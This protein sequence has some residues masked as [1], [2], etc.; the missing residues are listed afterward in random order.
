MAL[1][2]GASVFYVTNPLM[3]HRRQHTALDRPATIRSLIK[4]PSLPTLCIVNGEYVLPA[5]WDLEVGRGDVVTFVNL[6]QGGGDSN[7]LVVL[8]AV[9]V[10]AVG[11][12]TGNPY[13]VA[14]GVGTLVSGLVGVPSFTPLATPEAS[15]SSTYSVNLQGNSARLGQTIPVPYGRHIMVPDF[16]AQPYSEYD[17]N[18]DQYYHALL[19]LGMQEMHVVEQIAI[20]D[21]TLDHFQGVQQQLIGP[22]YPGETLSIVNPAVVNAVEVAQQDVKLGEYVGPF[23]VCGPGLSTTKIGIDVAFPK[24]LYLANNNGDLQEKSIQW[25]VE[26]RSVSNAG[27]VAGIWTTLG[28]ETF[29]AAKNEP[30]RRTYNYTV[31]SGRYEVRLQRLDTRD[32]NIR[33]GHDIQWIGMRAY[34]D[35]AAPLEPN[36]VYLAL[37]IKANN[38]LSG[39]SQRRVQVIQRRMLKTWD[40]IGGWSDYVETSNPAWICADIL[41]NTIYGAKLTDDRIDLETLK[42]LADLWDSRNDQ[43]NGIFD[44]R[45]TVWGALQTVSQVGRAVPIMRSTVFT[46]VRDSLQEIPTALFSMHNIVRGSFSVTYSMRTEND[47]DGLELEY[48]DEESWASAQIVVPMPG[49]ADPI[50]VARMSMLGITKHDQAER[51]CTHRVYDSY[52]RRTRIQFDTEMEGFLPAFGDLIAVSHD[53]TGW[54]LSGEIE[55]WAS[56]TAVCT[57]D[58]V[59]GPGK[60][61]AMLVDSQGDAFGPYEVAQGA[62]DRMMTFIDLPEC[63]IYTGAEQQRTRFSVGPSEDYA[64][65]C[66]VLRL[67]PKDDDMV[68]ITAVVEDVR[69]HHDA[70][71]VG[72]GGG[73]SPSEGRAAKYAPDGLP[74]YNGATDDQQNSY[75]Y[76][77]DADRTVGA[78]DDPGYVYNP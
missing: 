26:A 27:G 75:G 71:F 22:P 8:L 1:Y 66:R 19:C 51:E 64:R 53:V 43:F 12:F 78:S 31:A 10:T 25:M 77:S 58:I 72:T 24:G 4:R 42:E 38:Q 70:S 17:E 33:A 59:W 73:Y 74:N 47:P 32:D 20:D 21:T 65:L 9:V 44:R 63:E 34:L 62:G 56:P 5:D 18:G 2:R 39:L 29:S 76:Y 3:T 13:I 45:T 52:Y 36:A 40:P 14:A 61:Y 37:R 67:Q 49:V 46:F 54:G 15:L 28:V 6:P 41:K 7:P 68:Q 30:I 16:A 35:M 57:E 48:F 11:I 60:Y 50:N 23:T 55:A 69:V